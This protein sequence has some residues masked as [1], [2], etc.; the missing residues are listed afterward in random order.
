MD[1]LNA[2][3]ASELIRPQHKR[4]ADEISH[5]ATFIGDRDTASIRYL[6]EITSHHCSPTLAKPSAAAAG[7]AD[8]IAAMSEIWRFC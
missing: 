5:D 1:H 7:G 2:K 4:R 8:D 6:E 3:N